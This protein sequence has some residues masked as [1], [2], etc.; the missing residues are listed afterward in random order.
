MPPACFSPI[1]DGR[2]IWSMML[3]FGVGAASAA[4]MK[5]TAVSRETT[6]RID[7]LHGATAPCRRGP[8]AI[9]RTLAKSMSQVDSRYNACVVFGSSRARSCRAAA[10]AALAQLYQFAEKC[11]LASL[12][13]FTFLVAHTP[14]IG[15]MHCQLVKLG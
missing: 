12:I 14:K 15:L 7:T 11:G 9:S 2:L 3:G 8:R 4:A 5:Q 1:G 6:R 10:L 13:G